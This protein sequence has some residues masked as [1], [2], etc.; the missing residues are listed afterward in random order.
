MDITE[1]HRRWTRSWVLSGGVQRA[2]GKYFIE[3]QFSY[4]RGLSNLI[5][6]DNRYFSEELRDNFAY[7]PDDVRVHAFRLGLAF[8]RNFTIPQKKK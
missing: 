2:M 7:V 1:Q 3:L 5:D 6:E 4:E 8:Y